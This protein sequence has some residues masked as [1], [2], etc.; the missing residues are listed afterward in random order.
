MLR[1]HKVA[2][3]SNAVLRLRCTICLASGPPSG[4]IFGTNSFIAVRF[5][6]ALDV[7]LR[8]DQALAVQIG[9]ERFRNDNGSVLLLVIF[10]DRYPCA[11]NG[12]AG[13]VQSV[14]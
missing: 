6:H 14:D 5:P 11:A 7:G 13:S 3:T 2:P 1:H 9:P 10:D 8:P 4:I 12:Q